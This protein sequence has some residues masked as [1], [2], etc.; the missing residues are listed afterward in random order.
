M[1]QQVISADSHVL[2]PAD[3]WSSR[4]PSGLRDRGP[5]LVTGGQLGWSVDGGAPEPVTDL[6]TKK[7]GN[8]G[9][10]EDLVGGSS[11]PADR[12]R[13]QTYDAVDA[14]V[15]YPH[16]P[17]WSAINKASDAELKLACYRAYN[18]WIAEF[19]AHDPNRL[20]G[21]A[22][23]P[24]TGIDDA[25]AELKRAA[26]DLKLRGAILD[27]WPNGGPTP[28]PAEDEKLWAVAEE[29][30]VPLSVH[31]GLTPWL[32]PAAAPVGPGLAPASDRHRSRQRRLARAGV[33]EHRRLLPADVGHS[34]GVVGQSRLAAERLRPPA[35]LV[36][37]RQ[38]SRGRVHPALRRRLPPDVGELR[39]HDG[40]GVPERPG[41]R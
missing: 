1:K 23:I 26:G 25:V 15:L 35:L 37:V 20:H 13:E 2:E 32:T 29:L 31:K 34:P 28:N 33:D 27:A 6:L 19:A 41:G 8:A 16:P 10:Y 3:L 40:F 21:L 11:N 18:D 36:H 39:P 24:T 14:E 30:G 22:K 17:A 38:R 9:N 4:L 12:V 5:K 7:R